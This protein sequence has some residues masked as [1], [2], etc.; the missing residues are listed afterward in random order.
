M[1]ESN[2]PRVGGELAARLVDLPVVPKARGEGE[3]AKSDPRVEPGQ[4]AG[5]VGQPELAPCRSK[6]PTR[7]TGAP[8]DL[9]AVVSYSRRKEASASTTGPG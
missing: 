7:S 4:G 6:T 1:V 9:W 3:Q 5:T 2:S 8:A